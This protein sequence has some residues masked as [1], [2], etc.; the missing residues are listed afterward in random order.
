MLTNATSVKSTPQP[1]RQRQRGIL[2]NV[3]ATATAIEAS[4]VGQLHSHT[5]VHN[6]MDWRFLE[7]IASIPEINKKYG[8]YI[9]SKVCAELTQARTFDVVPPLLLPLSSQMCLHRGKFPTITTP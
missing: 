5:M 2:G 3:S 6:P 1:W 8:S 9:N 4:T 7:T